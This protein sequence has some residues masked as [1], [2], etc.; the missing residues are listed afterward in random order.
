[1]PGRRE[2]IEGPLTPLEA[3][4]VAAKDIL[5]YRGLTQ[6]AASRLN[7]KLSVKTLSRIF[8]GEPTSAG[9]LRSLAGILRL[10]PQT[11]IL[12]A[13]NNRKAIQALVMLRP[14]EDEPLKVLLLE[15]MDRV[16]TSHRRRSTDT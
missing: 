6:V 15:V 14:D 1:M 9:S 8:N 16:A 7:H 4:G 12:M 10:P 3:A 13:D 5:D 2:P 11:F